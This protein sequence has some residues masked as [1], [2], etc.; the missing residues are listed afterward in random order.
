MLETSPWR[1]PATLLSELGFTTDNGWQFH[2][3]DVLLS[4]TEH[5]WTFRCST[6]TAEKDWLQRPG[7]WKPSSRG[8]QVL[9]LPLAQLQ[10]STDSAADEERDCRQVLEWVLASR[11]ADWRPPLEAAPSISPLPNDALTARA[12]THTCQGELQQ[13]G[14]RFWIDYRLANLPDD[15]AVER[16]T[17]LQTICQASE[18]FRMVRVAVDAGGTAVHARVDLSGM[19]ASM[20]D[21]LIST[22][23]ARLRATVAALLPTIT[24][25]TES[26]V[27]SRALALGGPM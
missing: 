12:G 3:Q 8:T 15:L 11:N 4:L 5:W 26:G 21:S 17:W 19:A 25:L 27:E 14:E 9:D 23:A 13:N 6:P 10:L 24:F 22:T 18:R 7:L 2:R 20:R 1:A 16:L